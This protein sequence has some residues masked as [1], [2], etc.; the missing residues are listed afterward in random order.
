[1][2]FSYLKSHIVYKILINVQ[3]YTWALYNLA[4]WLALI[5]CTA[6]IY[7][8]SSEQHENTTYLFVLRAQRTCKNNTK[9]DLIAWI[10]FNIELIQSWEILKCMKI[11][12]VKREKKSKRCT[13]NSP[14]IRKVIKVEW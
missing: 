1:M 11:F 10:S 2:D 8:L 12:T 14:K 6:F 13:F 4:K 3:K 7:K 9:R 5:T